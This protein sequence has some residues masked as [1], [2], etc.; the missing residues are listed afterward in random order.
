MIVKT[1]HVFTKSGLYSHI[2]VSEALVY[3][4]VIRCRRLVSPSFATK[5]HVD[6]ICDR[7]II[8]MHPSVCQRNSRHTSPNGSSKILYDSCHL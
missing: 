3:A 8:M 1:S 2:I 6:V 4:L 5:A 7:R